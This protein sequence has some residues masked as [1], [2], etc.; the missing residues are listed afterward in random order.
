MN[1]LLLVKITSIRERVHQP[2]RDALRKREPQAPYVDKVLETYSMAKVTNMRVKFDCGIIRE[3]DVHITPEELT[4]K[5]AREF[6]LDPRDISCEILNPDRLKPEFRKALGK[7]EC[8]DSVL[9]PFLIMKKEPSKDFAEALFIKTMSLQG[10]HLVSKQ[11]AESAKEIAKNYFKREF[12]EDIE[13]KNLALCPKCKTRLH[14]KE[15]RHKT[16][17]L[18]TMTCPNKPWCKWG[19]S[20]VVPLTGP[21]GALERGVDHGD[22]GEENPTEIPVQTCG[23]QL[24]LKPGTGIDPEVPATEATVKCC[25]SCAN[26]PREH[27]GNDSCLPGWR[28]KQVGATW[29]DSLGAKC[30]TWR[31]HNQDLSDW[32]K[33]APG[34]IVK[35]LACGE[36][37]LVSY[38]PDNLCWIV[39]C[40]KDSVQ[41]TLYDREN[42]SLVK[43]GIVIH[44]QK[45]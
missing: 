29:C 5:L 8:L 18:V 6:S 41:R 3:F 26:R 11:F 17:V 37:K 39:F 13:T 44:A 30:P 10:I 24:Q 43:P 20:R 42:T 28:A 38:L 34:S 12:E 45:E 36:C 22:L 2:W 16:H 31:E 25:G 21:R 32:S 23:G 33:W 27:G 35:S 7:S 14:K 15:H 1:K 9:V 4:K 40:D 19:T